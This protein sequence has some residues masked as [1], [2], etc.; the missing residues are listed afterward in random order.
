L[1][2][3]L[4][5]ELADRFRTIRRQLFAITRLDG[6][7]QRADVCVDVIAKTDNAQQIITINRS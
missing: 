7:A 2:P 4:G 6:C 5:D 1:R 3:A